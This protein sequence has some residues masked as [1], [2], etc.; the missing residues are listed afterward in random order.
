MPMM[1]AC[2]RCGVKRLVGGKSGPERI[3]LACYRAAGLSGRGK[4]APMPEQQWK[5]AHAI[6]KQALAP[7]ESWWA[8]PAARFAENYA[9][10]LPRLMAIGPDL[11]KQNSMLLD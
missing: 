10:E 5:A 3:C 1:R 9:K 7:R 6:D 2:P 8:V 4:R 11:P